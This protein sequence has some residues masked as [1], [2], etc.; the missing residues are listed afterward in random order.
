MNIFLK[1]KQNNPQAATYRN[2]TLCIKIFEA[3]PYVHMD[4]G[5]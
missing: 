4:L 3:F 5:T 1:T 2:E